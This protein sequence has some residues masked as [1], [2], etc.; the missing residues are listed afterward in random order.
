MTNP[1]EGLPYFLH[2]TTKIVTD[3]G[4]RPVM[5]YVVCVVYTFVN[6]PRFAVT[7]TRLFA[8]A[9]NAL[10]CLLHVGYRCRGEVWDER[11]YGLKLPKEVILQIWTYESWHNDTFLGDN[12]WNVPLEQGAW[13]ITPTLKSWFC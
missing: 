3:N 4:H 6:S 1:R 5:W 2:K 12:D 10:R 13:L 9:A 8:L 11:R 7:P